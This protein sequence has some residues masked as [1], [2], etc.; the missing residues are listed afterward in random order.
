MTKKKELE[1]SFEAAMSELTKIVEEM[2][3]SSLTLEDSLKNFERGVQLTRQCQST[4]KDA[5]QHVK[6]LI[7]NNGQFE[8]EKFKDQD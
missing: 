3:H 2:E 5:E 1:P 4:L 8:L 7:E 6:I